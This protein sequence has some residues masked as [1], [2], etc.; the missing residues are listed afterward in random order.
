METREQKIKLVVKIVLTVL[1]VTALPMVGSLSLLLL[2]FGGEFYAF[3]TR[4]NP[5][6]MAQK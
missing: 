6:D 2:A 3:D 1:I 5:F 4:D